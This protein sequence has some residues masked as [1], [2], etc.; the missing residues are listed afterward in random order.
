V[1]YNG[2]AAAG[3]G[4]PIAFHVGA[5]FYENTHPLLEEIKRHHA[6]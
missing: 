3:Y 4:K 2:N 5:D 1:P 6:P